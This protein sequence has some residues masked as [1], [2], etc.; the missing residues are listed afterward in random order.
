MKKI[1]SLIAA[2]AMS[3]ALLTANNVHHDDYMWVTVPDHADWL[4][5]VGEKAVIRIELLHAGSPVTGTVRYTVSQDKLESDYKDEVTLKD[6]IATIKLDAVRKPCFRDVKLNY[7]DA[8]GTEH[9]HHVKIGFDVEKIQPVTKMPKDFDEFWE[10]ARKEVSTPL[11]YTMTKNEWASKGSTDCWHVR[12]ETVGNH[13]FYGN[14][15]IPK[16]TQGKSLPVVVCPPGAGVKQIAPRQDYALA[17]PGFI[18]FEYEIHG[19]DNMLDQEFYRELSVAMSTEMGSYIRRDLD[20]KDLYYMRH[21]YQGLIK[22][23]DF[24]T[25]LPQ[26]DGRNVFSYG[27][28]QG[29]ALSIVSAGIDSRVTACVAYYPAM[30]EMAGYHV[31]G[32][33]GGW[34]HFG[35]T[36]RIYTPGVLE[37]IP[38]YDV[39]NFARKV[40]VPTFLSFGYNDDVCPPT[41]SYMVWNTLDCDKTIY[42]VPFTEHWNTEESRAAALEWM[43][44]HI[45]Q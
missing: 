15:Y 30:V 17:A 10:K 23:I 9:K 27:G 16:D 31:K 21:V 42:P 3:L 2:L 11:R 24:V 26:W 20:F 37:T 28:S 33:T 45:K 43:K 35:K 34:P 18:V 14:L 13:L 44:Q 38:Y 12:L 29:G 4:Y 5:K 7:K 1:I 32:N 19:L 40:S 25:S 39:I 6:G 22:A 8:R 41:T 36:P